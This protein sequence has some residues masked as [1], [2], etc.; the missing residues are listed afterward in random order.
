MRLG[1]PRT[2][3]TGRNRDSDGVGGHSDRG[4][5]DNGNSHVCTD[6]AAAPFVSFGAAS[7]VAAATFAAGSYSDEGGGLR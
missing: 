3:G 6:P 2:V 4:R 5:P 7:D 1:G